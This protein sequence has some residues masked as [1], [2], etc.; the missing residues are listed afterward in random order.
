M[1][2]WTLGCVVP[3][4]A[5]CTTDASGT[6]PEGLDGGRDTETSGGDDASA[7]DVALPDTGLAETAPPDTTGAD[8]AAV[9][10]ATADTTA[11]TFVVD[12]ALSDTSVAD[13]LLADTFDSAATVAT[14]CKELHGL[15]PSLP[16]G[17]YAIDPDGAAAGASFDVYC[18]MST[19]GGGWTLVLAYAHAAATTPPA[20]AGTRPTSPSS[21]FS[22]FNNAQM[23]ALSPFTEVRFFC[24][25]S[26]HSR[27]IHFTTSNANAVSYIRGNAST[28]NNDAM[29]K[30]GFVALAGHTAA[31]PATTDSKPGAPVNPALDRRML[32]FPFY[33][34]GA[35]HFAVGGYGTRWECDDWANSGAFETL[36]QVWVR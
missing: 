24:S 3:L 11:D 30:T 15:S 8:A 31:L 20:V 7:G 27:R 23:R 32:D 17:V 34:Y 2:R 14:S 18:D 10:T 26:L 28:T 4:I 6:G 25:T 21:G 22:H 29:W 1:A 35:T 16:S 33:D 36:H 9:D 13:T 19:D 12:T 5:A